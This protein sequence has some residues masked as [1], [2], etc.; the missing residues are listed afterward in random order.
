MMDVTTSVADF[1]KPEALRKLTAAGGPLSSSI[2]KLS[3]SSRGIPAEKD[4]HFYNNFPE[5]KS[6]VKTIDKKSKEILEKVGALSELWGKARPLPDDSDDEYDW[7]VTLND[8]VLERLD[9]SIDEFQTVRKTEEENGVKMDSDGGFQVVLGRKNKKSASASVSAN[10]TVEK[11]EEKVGEGVKVAT[12]PKPKVPFHV[13]N[14]RRPQDEYKIIVNNSNQ[15][16]EHVWLQKSEDGSRFMHPLEELS[17]LDFV[18]SASVIEPIEPPP[19]EKTP[20]KYVEHVKD[21]KQLAAKLR[22]VD[23][24]AVDLEHNQYRS[25]QGMTCLM[26]IST[27][28][29]DFV[30][31]TLKL[32]VQVGPYLREVFKDPTKKKVMHGAD[33]DIVWLQRD[34]GIYVCNLFDTGQASRVLK[35][36]RKSLEYLLHHFCGVEAKKE[37]QNADWRMRPLPIEMMRYAR[38][39]THY[40]LYIYDVMRMKL[41]ELPPDPESSDSPMVEVYKRSYDICMQLY[42]KELLTDS[43]YLHIYGLQGAG[44]NAQQLAIVAGL[45]EWRDAIARAED[46]STGYVLPNRTLV[47]IAKQMPLN[48]NKLRWLVKSK[49]PYVEHNLSAVVSVIRHS[50]QN[51]AAYEAAAKLLNERRIAMEENALAATEEDDGFTPESPEHLK[52]DAEAEAIT[53]GSESLNNNTCGSS[54]TEKQQKN[55]SLEHGNSITKVSPTSKDNRI[56]GNCENESVE[57]ATSKQAEV[58]VPALRKPSR[59]LGMLLGGSAK[60]KLDSDKRGKDETKLEQIKSSLNLPLPTFT[61]KNEPSRQ[62]LEEEAPALPSE[63]SLHKEPVS[64]PPVTSNLG[65]IIVLEDDDDDMAEPMNNHS[66]EAAPAKNNSEDAAKSSPPVTTYLGDIIVLDDD[67]DDGGR[68]GKEPM[69]SVSETAHNVQQAPPVNS[70]LEDDDPPETLSELSSSFQ[71]CFQSME[72][73]RAA[74]LAEKSKGCGSE[75]RF[76]PF[77]YEEARKEVIF[78]EEEGSGKAGGETSKSKK[79]SA[80]S[81]GPF[82]TELENEFQQGKRRQAFPASGNRSYTFH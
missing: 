69:D 64:E 55:S 27:R 13:A 4:F 24:F 79:K 71:K 48:A 22:G 37:Y 59:G 52:M 51:Y 46:E 31:D 47:E 33:R 3:G 61:D 74:K 67:S 21:L 53:I 62:A 65:D 16:F 20:F 30:V 10:C 63:S 66:E 75:P 8:D 56:V 82:N 12:K 18:G 41:L 11:S 35:L 44:L 38:E 73:S 77:N 50:I 2:A 45:C 15:P 6:P 58:I 76:E 49:H 36:E 19:I 78:G 60:R 39:D 14:I 26:Q 29:E 5:F 81:V 80:G 17:A 42:Q 34:F 7:L 43:S 32:R 1:Q 57:V 9:S 28:S 54:V 23:E 68:K 25:F 72:E 40:L 70:E